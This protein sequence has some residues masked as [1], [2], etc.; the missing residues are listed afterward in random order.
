MDWLSRGLPVEGEEADR[1]T[2]GILAVEPTLLDPR[3]ATN[4]AVKLID[5]YD[6]DVGVVV[7]DDGTVVGLLTREAADKAP[8]GTVEASME[9]GPKT[10]RANEDPDEALDYMNQNN[11]DQVVVSGPLGGLIGVLYRDVVERE[12][13]GER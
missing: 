1:M 6:R 5:Q 13:G 4:E 11:L 7:A 10:Y 8:N 9:L 12:M 3:M 2:V